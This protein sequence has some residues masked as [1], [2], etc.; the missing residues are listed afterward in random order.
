[1]ATSDGLTPLHVAIKKGHL[2]A[3]ACGKMLGDGVV[4]HLGDMQFP[5]R[6]IYVFGQCL[7]RNEGPRQVVQALLSADVCKDAAADGETP[8]LLAIRD[9][10]QQMVRCLLSARAKLKKGLS[11]V[12]AWCRLEAALGS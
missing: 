2:Q 11:F 1:M 4:G 5:A 6:S 8:L 9:G 10:Q 12:K 7:R 3:G